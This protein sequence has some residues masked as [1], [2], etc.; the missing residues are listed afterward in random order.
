MQVYVLLYINKLSYMILYHYIVLSIII[1]YYICN[2]QTNR[3]LVIPHVKV[4]QIAWV[5]YIYV[6]HYLVYTW[7]IT[8]VNYVKVDMFYCNPQT[9]RKLDK[10]H[11]WAHILVTP[12]HLSLHHVVWYNMF[13]YNI[14]YYHILS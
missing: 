11:G 7:F 8:T 1:H 3:K 10:M 5:D 13:L 9:N 2:P 4:V 14:T 6:T 12:T